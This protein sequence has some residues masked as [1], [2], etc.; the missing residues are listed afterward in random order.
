MLAE[1]LLRQ[2]QLDECKA[3]LV[4]QIKQAPANMALRIFLFQLACVEQDWARAQS[5][6]TLLKTLS[7][8]N[9]PLV[10]TYLSL[11]ESERKRQSV[12]AGELQSP[13]LGPRPEWMDHF[14]QAMQLCNQQQFAQAQAEAMTGAEQA[15]AISGKVDGKAFTWLTD[16]DMRFGPCFEMM[17]NGGYFQLPYAAVRRIDFEAVEDLRDLVWRP[18]QLTL[19]DNARF[20]VF[21]P[22]RYPINASTTDQ[23]KLSRC[24]DWQM[25]AEDFYIGQGQRV[26]VSDTDEFPLLAIQTIEF[27]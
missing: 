11:L 22:V 26:L 19:K 18:A 14:A 12:L 5:Q 21:F 6:L 17:L 25:P 3:Q 9:L 4:A 2:G 27:D 1:A 16:G 23:Q 7:D 20:I 10:N 15:V 13:C 8:A 24:C